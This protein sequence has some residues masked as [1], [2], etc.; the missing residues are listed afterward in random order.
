M[1]IKQLSNEENVKALF[2][3]CGFVVN[4]V[5]KLENQYWPKPWF[6]EKEIRCNPHN[7]IRH[8]KLNFENPWWLVYTNLG[9]IEIGP[10]K[11]VISIDWRETPLQEVVTEDDVTKAKTY[12]HAHNTDKMIEYLLK[13]NKLLVAIKKD[14]E[15]VVA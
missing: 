12:V 14:V 15:E 4:R 11:R 3:T 9:L 2:T 7:I 13:I 1:N 10:R 5:F 6:D 8:S